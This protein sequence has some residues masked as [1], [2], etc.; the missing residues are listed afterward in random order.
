ML[1]LLALFTTIIYGK[2]KFFTN[3][4][5]IELAYIFQIPVYCMVAPNKIFNENQSS[6]CV[7]FHDTDLTSQVLHT[8]RH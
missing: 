8:T 6:L 3:N 4:L 2:K 1:Y 7:I 5:V